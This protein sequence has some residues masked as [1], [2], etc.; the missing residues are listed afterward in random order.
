VTEEPEQY[1]WKEVLDEEYH[2]PV[3]NFKRLFKPT[4]LGTQLFYLCTCTKPDAT[5]Y[6]R[7][8]HS[9]TTICFP[10]LAREDNI[11]SRSAL[12]PLPLDPSPYVCRY[13]L[14]DKPMFNHFV[15]AAVL[16]NS[17]ILGMSI[18]GNGLPT[19]IEVMLEMMFDLIF[20]MEAS[21]SPGLPPPG[22]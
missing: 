8:M 1:P 9:L 22:H 15:L 11:W 10:V 21:F 2:P 14:Q 5:E 7:V 16:S 3:A 20:F 12:A 18:S 17:V 6:L 4:G 13:R 19:A